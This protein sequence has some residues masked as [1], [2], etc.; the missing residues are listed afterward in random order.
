MPCSESFGSETITRKTD[1]VE[2]CG[3]LFYENQKF[4]NCFSKKEKI[5]R[6]SFGSVFKVMHKLEGYYYAV[7]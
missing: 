6:G 3:K 1:H 4:E 7:K 2:E 5:G